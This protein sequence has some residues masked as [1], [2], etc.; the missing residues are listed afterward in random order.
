MTKYIYI[1]L[2]I[3]NL[4]FSTSVIATVCINTSA[5]PFNSTFASGPTM[6]A[7]VNSNPTIGTVIYRARDRWD[8]TDAVNRIGDWDGNV[9]ASDCPAGQPRQFGAYEF[10]DTAAC[11]IS[12]PANISAYTITGGTRSIAIN[13][14]RV[15]SLNPQAGQFDIESVVVHEF[16]HMLGMAHQSGDECT[17]ALSPTCATSPNIET[18]GSLT[19]TGETCQRSLEAGDRESANFLY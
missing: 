8:V 14:N 3:I 17:N 9:T 12:V 6:I 4:L 15:W 16:G 18:M 2:F 1:Y 19:H 13:L 7:I 11:S 10:S 5:L